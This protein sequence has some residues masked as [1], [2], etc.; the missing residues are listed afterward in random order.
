MAAKLTSI[1]QH[2]RISFWHHS[3]LELVKY[4]NFEALLAGFVNT[5]NEENI[6]NTLKGSS[7]LSLFP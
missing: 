1:P 6:A 3:V 7:S 4:V 2:T 5:M